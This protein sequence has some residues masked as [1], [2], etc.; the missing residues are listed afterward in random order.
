MKRYGLGDTFGRVLWAPEGGDGGG[1]TPPAGDPPATPGTPPAQTWEAWIEAQPTEVKTLYQSH[2]EG[3]RNTVQATRTERDNLARQLREATTK[4][5]E[6]SEA[7]KSLETL[8]G[9]LEATSR[10]AAFYEQ[11]T[12]KDVACRNPK[13]AY[14]AAMEAG[15]LDDKGAV[16]WAKLKAGYPELF[17]TPTTTPTPPVNPTNPAN[18]TKLT[19]DAVKKMTPDEIN[20][21]WDDVQAVLSQGA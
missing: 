9:Q 2:T 1:G 6:G 20:K 3:L 16:D 4:L 5:E 12:T 11:A 15:A 18:P 17:G 10:K 7:R 8:T 21:R 14:L 13:L 19:L